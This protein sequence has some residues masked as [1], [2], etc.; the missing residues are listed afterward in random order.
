MTKLSADVIR[1][2]GFE[3]PGP[4]GDRAVMAP[5]GTVDLAATRAALELNREF[6]E[7]E[8]REMYAFRDKWGAPWSDITD[9]RGEWTTRA[10]HYRQAILHIDAILKAT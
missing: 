9:N 7:R 1:A 3:W 2:R 6:Y 10:E 5:D 8:L 4:V